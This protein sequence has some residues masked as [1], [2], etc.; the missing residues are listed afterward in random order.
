MDGEFRPY[1]PYW[2]VIPA[3]AFVTVAAAWAIGL[4]AVFC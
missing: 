3:L 2:W 1:R 4:Y